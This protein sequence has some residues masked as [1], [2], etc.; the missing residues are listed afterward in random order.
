MRR[1]TSLRPKIDP[2]YSGMLRYVVVLSHHTG[3]LRYGPL[4]RGLG[5]QASRDWLI[6]RPICAEPVTR[7]G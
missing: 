6:T 2:L 3:E 7:S 4:G 5:A 1:W